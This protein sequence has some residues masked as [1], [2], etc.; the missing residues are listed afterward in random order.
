MI[1]LS[2]PCSGRGI[3]GKGHGLAHSAG[4]SLFLRAI[5]RVQTV[6]SPDAY[7][8]VQLEQG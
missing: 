4:I 8:A 7:G 5:A 1:E 6:A 3:F 2:D